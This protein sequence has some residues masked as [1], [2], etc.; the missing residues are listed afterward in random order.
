MDRGWTGFESDLY[1]V[2]IGFGSGFGRV[3]IGYGLGLNRVWIRFGSG[4]A[5][6]TGSAPPTQLV[7]HLFE[8]F[9]GF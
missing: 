7:E 3:L 1:R 6:G 5:I 8:G 4:L 2:C 9:T